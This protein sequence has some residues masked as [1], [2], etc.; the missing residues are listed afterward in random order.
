MAP[1]TPQQGEGGTESS[2]MTG[3]SSNTPP[4]ETQ[5][6]R[7]HHLVHRDA[8]NAATEN[9]TLDAQL[10]IVHKTRG[11]KNKKQHAVGCRCRHIEVHGCQLML[12][13]TAGVR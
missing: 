4:A 12:L 10:K 7:R 6:Q 5:L 3:T 2:R 9:M 1:Q 8:A 11:S 13:H